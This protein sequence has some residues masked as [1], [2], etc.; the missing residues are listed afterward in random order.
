MAQT[1]FE[2]WCV[3]VSQ[4]RTAI[5][6]TNIKPIRRGYYELFLQ[7]QLGMKHAR[8][9]KSFTLGRDLNEWKGHHKRMPEGLEEK[10]GWCPGPR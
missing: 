1:V 3:R 5:V 9:E 4:T 10:G 8:C 2:S 6:F 7:G